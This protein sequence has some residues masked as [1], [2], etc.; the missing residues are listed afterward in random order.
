VTVK[1]PKC[2]SENTS[3]SQFCKKCATPLPSSREIDISQTETLLPPR[4]DLSPGTVFASRY[5]V[6]EELG[7]G[8]MGKVYK[9]FDKETN[10]KVALKLIKPEVAADR[11]TIERFRNELKIARDISHKHICRMYD[12]GREADNYFITMEYVSGEDLRGLIRKTKRLDI[13]TAISIAKQVCEGLVEAHRLGVVHRDLKPSNIMIDREGDA[14]IMDFGIARSLR[15]KGI[16]GPGAVIGTLEYMS[17]EQVDGKEADQRADLYSLSIIL[18]EIVTGT[19]P[20]EGE[21]AFAIG[22]KHKSEPPENPKKLNP[23]IPDDLSRLILKGLEK[24]REKRYQ[25]A[26]EVLNELKEIEQGLQTTEKVIPRRKPLTSREITVKFSFRKLVIPAIAVAAVALGAILLVFLSNRQ[27]SK[28]PIL[29]SHK[30]LTFTGDAAD[31]AI[32]PDGKF[33][34]YLTG[35]QGIEPKVWVQDMVSGRSIE[36]FSANNCDILSWTPDGAEIAVRAYK[37]SEFGTFL[38]PRLGGPSRQIETFPC[39]A[40]SPDGS[41]FAEVVQERN[42]A[43]GNMTWDSATRPD[44]TSISVGNKLKEMDNLNEKDDIFIVNKATGKSNSFKVNAPVDKFTHIDWSPR[45]DRLLILTLDKENI[46][47]IWTARTDGDQQNLVLKDSVPLFSPRWAPRGDAIFY[48]RGS[49]SNQKE[50]WKLPIS[51]DTGKP[52]KTSSLVLSG[53]PMGEEL[54]LSADGKYLLYTRILNFSN[55]WLARLDGSE[56]GQAIK[57]KQLTS[58]TQEVGMNSISPDG[59]L[60]AFSRGSI[61]TSNIYVMPIE[62]GNPT[63]L[64]FFNS[65]N[66]NPVWSPDGTEIAFV[67]DEGGESHIWKVSAQGG[68]PFRFEKTKVRLN[69]DILWAPGPYIWYNSQVGSRG[70]YIYRILNPKTEKEI[71]LAKDESEGWIGTPCISPDGKKV[72]VYWSK[73]PKSG[74]WLIS[75]EDF[76]Q[77]LVLGREFTRERGALWLDGWSDDGKWVYASEMDTKSGKKEYLMIEVESGKTKPLPIIPF[78]IERRTF[79]KLIDSK[80]II[81][82]VEKT[83]SDV[84]VIQN[85]DQI[86]K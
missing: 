36:V 71:S 85:F 19:V 39:L 49:S 37:D 45:G 60:I 47:S 75:A 70:Y 66:S 68:L 54:T 3:D 31:P 32:S 15:T 34:A 12:L 74:V 81:C 8:G 72:A 42:D 21:T 79:Y 63:Q 24:D 77:K 9:V 56:K 28:Q 2:H 73:P 57:T 6:I 13:G 67:S 52:M 5:Q 61:E 65:H 43:V 41:Y 53:I 4:E 18:Y 14:K 51:R 26:A 50:L 25:T 62:G 84:W 58:G 38:V 46:Y 86:I 22:L 35:Q 76:S 40:W 20:F 7:H 27:P 11:N 33:I 82:W 78:T 55:L 83:Q 59:K 64:T 80:P 44:G 16:T 23:Q 17:P 69:Y 10:S 30:Q 1:C 48:I 29:P